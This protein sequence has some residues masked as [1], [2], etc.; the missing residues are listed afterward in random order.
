MIRTLTVKE[1]LEFAAKTRLTWP[2]DKK[3][4]LVEDILGIKKMCL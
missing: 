3:E 1:I 2:N 4:I